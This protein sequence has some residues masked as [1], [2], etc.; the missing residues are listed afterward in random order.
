MTFLGLPRTPPAWRRG[1]V[2]GR[3]RT[4]NSATRSGDVTFSSDRCWRICPKPVGPRSSGGVRL[5]PRLPGQDPRRR[6]A[7]RGAPTA[8]RNRRRRPPGAA[9]RRHRR[10]AIYDTWE[11]E[12][13]VGRAVDRIF[14]ERLAEL[15]PGGERLYLSEQEI[16]WTKPGATEIVLPDRTPEPTAEGIRRAPLR[17]IAERPGCGDH[18][19]DVAAFSDPAVRPFSGAAVTFDFVKVQKLSRL[20]ASP[21]WPP[22]TGRSSVYA[23]TLR[24]GRNDATATALNRAGRASGVPDRAGL[25]TPGS[26]QPPRR[27]PSANRAA[28]SPAVHLSPFQSPSVAAPD[29]FSIAPGPAPCNGA[30]PA[31]TSISSSPL[32][33]SLPWFPS[34]TVCPPDCRDHRPLTRT[35]HP[36][37]GRRG[38]R[39]R[40]PRVG[41]RGARR[42][43]RCGPADR[44]LSRAVG[45]PTPL[46][47]SANASLPARPG[48]R[49]AGTR[50]SDLDHANRL[51][52][53][54]ARPVGSRGRRR[55]RP[56]RRPDGDGVRN[57]FVRR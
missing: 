20:T 8:G 24:P 40:V 30:D 38:V 4:T 50:L 31:G 22:A 13:P 26:S 7:G 46:R 44:A 49:S 57:G 12:D 18:T 36:P 56:A 45:L 34:L 19:P 43:V 25:R 6:L 54:A 9:E 39:R 17:S 29:D 14:Q 3:G 21:P 41:R 11:A 48:P 47:G 55:R 1:P 28:A 51:L 52:R 32:P 27:T 33:P 23:T 53:P 10:H 42:S 16:A 5:D 35:K 37:D 2:P 15:R